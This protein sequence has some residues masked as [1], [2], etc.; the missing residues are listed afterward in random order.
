[1]EERAKGNR[2]FDVTYL[3]PDLFIAPKINYVATLLQHLT[4][5][6]EKV[7]AVTDV[8]TSNLLEEAWPRL[9]LRRLA[10]LSVELSY[11]KDHQQ[12]FIEYIEKQVILDMLLDPILRKYFTEFR[13]F[14]FV[15]EHTIGSKTMLAQLFVIYEHYFREYARSV[16]KQQHRS[17]ELIEGRSAENLVETSKF[18]LFN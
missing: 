13:T 17:S 5:A 3:R 7:L 15:P 10:P 1:M 4:H 6:H 8:D 9:D 16:T 2:N 18:S 14:P 11:A 12:S